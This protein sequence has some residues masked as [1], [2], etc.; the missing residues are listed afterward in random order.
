M[1]IPEK[2][3]PATPGGG[4]P[5]LEKGLDLLEALAAE[6]G[7]LTQKQLAARIG[8]SVGEIF[9]MLGTLQRR[10]YISRD[11]RTG[12]YV[13]TLQLFQLATQHPPTRRLQQVALPIMDALAA[14]TRAFLP[15]QHG[16]RWAVPHRGAGGTAATDGLDGEARRGISV[17]N[18][19]CFCPR[20]RGLS[21]RRTA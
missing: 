1:S 15:S 19:I 21:D 13:L 17:F 16:E 5:A 8:R 9:R 14:S 10:G 3:E 7:G 20:H 11:P 18:G 4:A 2:P 6:P 12:E